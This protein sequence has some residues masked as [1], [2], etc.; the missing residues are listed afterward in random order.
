VIDTP[1]RQ[2]MAEYNTWM[3][4]NVFRACASILP[5]KLQQDCGAFF[6]S[7]YLSLSPIGMKDCASGHP[8][9]RPE[10]YSVY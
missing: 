1:Y 5:V 4:A 10:G 3:N 7:I 8:S 6:K 2:R 9:P